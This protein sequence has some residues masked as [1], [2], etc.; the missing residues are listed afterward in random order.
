MEY[1]HKV[2][3]VA[4]GAKV[5]KDDQVFRSQITQIGMTDALKKISGTYC[6]H[7]PICIRKILAISSAPNLL[8]HVGA[9]P[10]VAGDTFKHIRSFT[11]FI[12]LDDS[13]LDDYYCG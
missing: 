6:H 11:T 8:R 5:R 12:C 2:L 4:G 13:C 7:Y 9:S 10:T 1:L 3:E